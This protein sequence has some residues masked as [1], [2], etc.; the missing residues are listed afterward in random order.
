MKKWLAFV[1]VLAFMIVSVVGCGQQGEDTDNPANSGV[2]EDEPITISMALMGGPKTEDTWVEQELEKKLNVNF[3]FVMLP[4]W[5]DYKTKINLLISDPDAMPDVI[6]FNDMEK[7]FQQWVNAGL[8]VD[9]MPYLKEDSI[10][11]IDYYNPETLFYSYQDGSMYKLPGDVA[12]A[13]CMTTMIRKD[14]LD[15]LG[16]DV[17]ETLDE[18]MAVLAAFTHDDPDQNGK[19]DTYGLTGMSKDWRGF[20]PI[21]YALNSQPHHFVITDDDKIKHG[22][23]LPQTKEA[24]KVLAD[25]YADNIIDPTMLTLNEFGELLVQ[26]KFGSCYYWITSFNPGDTNMRSFKA[27]NQDG[28]YIYIE[29]IKG[30]DGFSSDEPEDLGG[31]C[32]IAITKAAKDPEAVFKVLDQIASPEIFKLWKFGEEGTHYEIVDGQYNPLIDTDEGPAVGLGLLEWYLNRKDEANIINSPDVIELFNKRAET[33]EALR[34]VRVRFKE[35]VRP[36]WAEYGA[37]IEGLRDEIFYGIIAGNL[38]I[39]EF[40]KYV[41]RFYEMG[42]A[43]IEKEAN[44]FY[45]KQ[46]DQETEFTEAYNNEIKP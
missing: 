14:W 29:P 34:D 6:W 38:P 2:N 3:E 42:G 8:V 26:G 23:V 9:M 1:L 4:G 27:N 41:E 43:E 39:D 37:D 45:E 44:E 24:L 33:S 46:A 10:N 15:N 21:L 13:S 16:L 19:D 11:I 36:M 35:Q 31:W 17:P 30:P 25:A 7:E 22:S 18:Y 28:E 5:D 32:H 40:D 12:E 20:A